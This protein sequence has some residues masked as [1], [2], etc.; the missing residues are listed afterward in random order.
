MRVTGPGPDRAGPRDMGREAARLHH[1]YHAPRIRPSLVRP[2]RAQTDTTHTREQC[3][4][5]HPLTGY[6]VLAR[7]SATTDF[8]EMSPKGGACPKKLINS[9]VSS[10]AEKPLLARAHQSFPL[11][12]FQTYF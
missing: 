1:R 4:A 11:L 3:P 10:C 9:E 5:G 2:P 6:N 7:P 8:Y 12:P